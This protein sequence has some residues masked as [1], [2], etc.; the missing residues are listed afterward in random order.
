M[1]KV[2]VINGS[3][4]GEKSNSLRLAEAFLKGLGETETRY[5]HV[6]QKQIAACRGCFNLTQFPHLGLQSKSNGEET[7]RPKKKEVKNGTR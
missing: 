7:V 6:A 2:L 1:M 3:P 4:R 5:F